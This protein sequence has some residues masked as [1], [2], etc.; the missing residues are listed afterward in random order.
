MKPLFTSLLLLCGLFANS[1]SASIKGSLQSTGGEAIPFANIAL[2]T[3]NDSV[4]YKAGISNE[5]GRFELKGIGAGNYF[6]KAIY[7]GYQDLYQRSIEVNESQ[8]LNLGVLT[9][10]SQTVELAEATVTASRAMV[11]IKPDRTVFNVTGTINSTGSDG[12]SLL[13]KAPSVTVD[14]NDNISVLGR[15]GVL[16]YV[17]GK[18]LPLTGPDLSNYLAKSE[19]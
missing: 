2:F 18:R 9:F 14:N 13:R 10:S 1:Q 17:D 16:L 4:L 19:R 7:L 11:E 15:S 6:L 8:E 3:T 12:L 5:S